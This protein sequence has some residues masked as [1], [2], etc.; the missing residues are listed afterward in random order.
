MD[1]SQERITRTVARIGAGAWILFA[2][3]WQLSNILERSMD[4]EGPPR[5]AYM[6]GYAAALV[7]A[8][9][10]VIVTAVRL[11]DASR[12]PR[13]L[14][15]LVVLVAGA[16]AV[17]LIGWALPV[18]ATV[19]GLGAALASTRLGRPGRITAIGFL[20]ST[21]VFFAMSALRVGEVDVYGDYPAAWITATWVLAAV[22][23]A[24]MYLMSSSPDGR[25]AGHRS[26]ATSGMVDADR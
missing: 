6:V 26:P 8:C 22:V 4:F 5:T 3:A 2:I 25:T 12:S 11:D 20:G 14:A 16:A 24:G 17:V 19:L 9:A 7:G 10:L 13:F 18:W 15:G 1:E 23:S 21:A